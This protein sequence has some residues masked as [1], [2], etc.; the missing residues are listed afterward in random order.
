MALSG[1]LPRQS[2]QRCFVISSKKNITSFSIRYLPFPF[3]LWQ[4]SLRE[5][6]IMLHELYAATPP[7]PKTAPLY[8]QIPGHIPGNAFLKIHCL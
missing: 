6:K 5:H 7:S 3:S 1:S 2:Y 8:F 4:F